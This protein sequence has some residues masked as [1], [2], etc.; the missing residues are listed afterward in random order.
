M[1]PQDA[2]ARL[3]D[4]AADSYHELEPWYQHLY[5]VLHPIVLAALAPL[6]RPGRALDVGCGSGFQTALLEGLAYETHGVDISPKLLALARRRA[7]GAW[8]AAGSAEALP[9]PDDHFDAVSCCGSTLSFVAEPGRALNE[10]GRVLRPGGRLLLECEHKWSLDLAWSLLSGLTRDSLGYHVSPALACRRLGRPL[11]AGFVL[12]YP[13]YGS[14]RVFTLPELRAMLEAAGLRIASTWGI[15]AITNVIPSTVL[16]RPRLGR[17]LT[18][19]FRGLCALDRS[20]GSRRLGR[21]FANSLVV[22]AEKRGAP[23][24]AGSAPPVLERAAR[25][26]AE[27]R[28]AGLGTTRP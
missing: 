21:S 24:A 10:I 9:Y 2:V 13:G 1:V 17:S 27:R 28:R 15:H 20:L 8:L 26:P 25:P 23:A 4:A 5:A 19:V 18:A 22:L 16:H 14:L 3:F 6:G 12:D 11:R 7:P